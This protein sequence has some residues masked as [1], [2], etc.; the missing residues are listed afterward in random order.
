MIPPD[1]VAIDLE[2]PFHD[3][4]SL[5]VVWHGHYYKYMELARTALLRDRGL[6]VAR[7]VELGYGL[8][9]IESRCRHSHPLRYGEKF[10]VSAWFRDIAHR[11]SIGYEITNLTA[12]KRAA[13]GRTSL[14]TLDREG[15][16]FYA[17]PEELLVH[18]RR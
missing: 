6:D 10:R 13:R 12:E 2:V 11:I 5:G 7:F 18:L 4:D 14:V 16:M 17:T 15:R 8:L 9:I 3:V 1:A